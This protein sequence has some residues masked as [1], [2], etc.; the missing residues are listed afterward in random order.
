MRHGW[1][2]RG[3]YKMADT[4]TGRDRTLL[5]KAVIEANGEWVSAETLVSVVSLTH[6]QFT[7]RIRELTE[8]GLIESDSKGRNTRSRSYRMSVK[9]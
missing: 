3:Q 4:K 2:P 5:L 1:G 6:A 9:S 8:E 7:M